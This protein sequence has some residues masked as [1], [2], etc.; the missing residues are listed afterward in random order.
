MAIA[1]AKSAAESKSRHS[2]QVHQKTMAVLFQRRQCASVLQLTFGAQ[3]CVCALKLVLGWVEILQK[4]P[5]R[6]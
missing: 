4:S 6:A 2:E 5:N 1:M 3:L